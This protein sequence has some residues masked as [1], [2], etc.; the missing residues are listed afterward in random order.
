M[1]TSDQDTSGPD[2][3]ASIYVVPRWPTAS[4]TADD[5]VE[6]ATGGLTTEQTQE[7]RMAKTLLLGAAQA[8]PRFAPVTALAPGIHIMCRVHSDFAHHIPTGGIGEPVDG[9][10]LAASLADSWLVFWEAVKA[11]PG[12]GEE[13]ERLRWQQPCLE[14]LRHAARSLGSEAMGSVITRT[15]TKG[16]AIVPCEPDGNALCAL[17]G[18][19]RERIGMVAWYHLPTE[20]IEDAGAALADS[21]LAL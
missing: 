4:T 9:A 3:R 11:G 16:W 10:T 7:G 19:A 18:G 5:S 15:P 12:A 1:N 14:Y 13:A 21:L 8:N 20:R 6:P 2:I 17:A